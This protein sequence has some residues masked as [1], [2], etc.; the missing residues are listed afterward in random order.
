M[1]SI[2]IGSSPSPQ[3]F[4]GFNYTVGSVAEGQVRLGQGFSLLNNSL[5]GGELS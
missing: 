2:H 3:F 1:R 4:D 5:L